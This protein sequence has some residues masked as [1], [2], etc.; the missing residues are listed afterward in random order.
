MIAH[1]ACL[2]V[3]AFPEGTVRLVV[4]KAG[5]TQKKQAKCVLHD[6]HLCARLDEDRTVCEQLWVYEL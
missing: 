2:C 4:P 3:C 6:Q 1:D 5:K